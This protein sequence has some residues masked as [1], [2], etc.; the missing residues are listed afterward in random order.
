MPQLI[1]GRVNLPDGPLSEEALR[2]LLAG[3]EAGHDGDHAWLNYALLVCL[4]LFLV[5]IPVVVAAVVV[6]SW[7]RCWPTSQRGS[8][9]LTAQPAAAVAAPELDLESQLLGGEV[10]VPGETDWLRTQTM[11]LQAQQK[12]LLELRAE[13]LQAC[14]RLGTKLAK[15]SASMMELKGTPTL[16]FSEDSLPPTISEA[17][18]Q[19]LKA[20]FPDISRDGC[21]VHCA[22]Q[23]LGAVALRI[24]TDAD[25]RP[26]AAYVEMTRAIGGIGGGRS[27]AEQV[28]ER[29][30]A[31]G[32]KAI[33]LRSVPDEVSFWE[34]MGYRT[35]AR[36]SVADESMLAGLGLLTWMQSDDECPRMFLVPDP[37]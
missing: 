16:A 31:L 30:T 19:L 14:R 3:Y 22:V 24:L 34:Y 18:G 25:G 33:I 17:C 29:A 4:M 1:P 23:P 28:E 6:R 7:A 37:M 27:L 12:R 20:R 15:A 36:M 5:M 35:K 13:D 11:A 10:Y 2:A 8:A 21:E 32:A 9:G 26:K